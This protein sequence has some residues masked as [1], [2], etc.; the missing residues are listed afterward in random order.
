MITLVIEALRRADPN[1]PVPQ[2]AQIR[3]FSFRPYI[4]GLPLPWMVLSAVLVRKEGLRVETSLLFAAAVLV[5]T[6]ITVGII[7]AVCF[8][9]YVG[10]INI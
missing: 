6:V 7:V 2:L 10:L 3:F 8:L 1:Q 5:V 9:P 4:L